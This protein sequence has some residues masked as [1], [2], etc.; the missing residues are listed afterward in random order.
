MQLFQE[1]RLNLLVLLI[2][3][4]IACS[5]RIS[6]DTQTD[7]PSTVTLNVHAKHKCMHAYLPSDFE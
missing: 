2:G 7:T 3:C 1:N 5:A 4:L 6:V